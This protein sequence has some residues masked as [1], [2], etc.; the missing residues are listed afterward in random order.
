MFDL[1]IV[2]CSP[3]VSSSLSGQETQFVFEGK[4][5]KLAL[6]LSVSCV[7]FILGRDSEKRSLGFALPQEGDNTLAISS[8]T[9]VL[10]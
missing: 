1:L 10:Q 4:E 6:R 3:S 5:S 8:S 7:L 9:G 2:F